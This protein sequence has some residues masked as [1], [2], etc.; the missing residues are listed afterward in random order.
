MSDHWWQETWFSGN[1]P[2]FRDLG[3][4]DAQK[5]GSALRAWIDGQTDHPGIDQGLQKSDASLTAAVKKGK[6]T[7]KSS[8]AKA[9]A[10]REQIAEIL[11]R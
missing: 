1:K 4:F 2:T 5:T 3:V 7:A 6:T 10:W 9:K 8:S 11:K